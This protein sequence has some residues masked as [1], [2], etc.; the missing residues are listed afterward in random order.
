MKL[1]SQLHNRIG[2]LWWYSIL[3]FVAQRFGDAVNMAV[4][5]WLVPKYIGQDELGA[6]LP[7]SQAVSLVGLPLSIL[8]IPFMKFLSVYG[9]KGEYGKIK[10]LLHDVFLGTAVL[11]VATMLIAWLVLP[12]F[13]L[14]VRVASG[15]LGLLI[16]IGSVLAAV[17]TIFGNA[18]QGLKLYKS[19]IW[20]NLLGAPMRLLTMWVAMPFRALSGYFA[21]QCAAPCTSIFGA[22]WVLRKR[23]GRTI[24]AAP[25]WRE[26]GR[27][28]IRYTIPIAV[29]TAI[30]TITGAVESL[31]IRHRLPDFESA[32]YYMITRFTDIASYF[33]SSFIVFL[34]PMVAGA[35]AKSSASKRVLVQSV[36]GTA[37]G[38]LAVGGLLAIFGGWLLSLSSLWSPYTPLAGMM[39]PICLLNVFTLSCGCFATYEMAQGRFRFFRYALPILLFRCAFLYAA[40]GIEFFHGMLP[41]QV[42]AAVASWQPC[43][44][45]FV[46]SVLIVGQLILLASFAADVLRSRPAAKAGI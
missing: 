27:A 25:Y 45:S 29:W 30:S 5:L 10:S 11:A 12:F 8:A 37:A 44:L 14:R 32:G 4:G 33:G 43:R 23:L 41:E 40:T 18:V 15:S 13:F 21:G 9:E 19:T 3:L 20:F 46:I 22:M 42:I 24:T 26:D 36:S 6:V 28:I 1:L 16:V 39:F 38:G 31:V 7:L 17:S 35:A 2:D 34:F